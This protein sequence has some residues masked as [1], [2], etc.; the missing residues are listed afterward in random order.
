MMQILVF[1]VS[2]Q[3]G[4]PISIHDLFYSKNITNFQ[5][6]SKNNG[7]TTAYDGLGMLIEQAALSYRIWNSFEPSTKDLKNKLG[8]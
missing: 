5:T 2:R 1:C 8:F 6:W 4:L 3:A 7:A